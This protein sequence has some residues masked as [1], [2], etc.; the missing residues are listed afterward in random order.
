MVLYIPQSYASDLRPGHP[1]PTDFG[2]GMDPKVQRSPR[3][4]IYSW[5][6]MYVI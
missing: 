4:S 2:W 5:I 6:M 1:Q 3:H